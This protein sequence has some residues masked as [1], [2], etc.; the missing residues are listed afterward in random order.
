MNVRHIINETMKV[1]EDD[2]APDVAAKPEV[3]PELVDSIIVNIPELADCDRD[4]LLKGMTVEMEHFDTVN[5]DINIVARIASDH[6]KEF[7]G[8]DYYAALDVMEHEL[9][10]TPGKEEAEHAPGGE[11]GPAVGEI[12]AGEAPMES[13]VGEK[14]EPKDDELSAMK[15]EANKK[16]ED[17]INKK[18]AEKK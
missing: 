9:L 13:K 17:K 2:L 8:K 16:E 3:T 1:N 6:L 5:G 14:K 4:M 12:P 10:E 18:A 11:E 15:K 7:A